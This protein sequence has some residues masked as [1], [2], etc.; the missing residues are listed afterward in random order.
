MPWKET[1]PMKERMR[2]VVTHEADLYAMKEQCERFGISRKTGYKWLERFE[3]EGPDGLEDRSRRPHRSPNQTAENIQALL[4][5][6]RLKHPRWGPEKLLDVVS[7]RHPELEL[8]A[9]STV[10]AILK[11]EGLVKGRRR[12]R[13]HKHPGKPM[14]SVTTPNQLWTADFK[15]EFKTLDG[16]WCYPLTVAD[17]YSRFVLGID[18]MLSTKAKGARVV[19][20]RLFREYGLPCGIRTDNGTPFVGASAIHGLSV[21]SVWWIKLGIQPER[22]LPGRPDQN[23]RHER[24]HRTMKDETQ[25][26]PAASQPAQQECFDDFRHE[27]NHDR[28][29]Q[30]LGQKRPAEVWKPSSRPYP[31]RIPEAEYPKH[32]QRR[33]VCCNGI[34]QFKN[35]R[36]FLSETMAKE[37]IGLEEIQ[38]GIWSIY[39]YNVLLGRFD[40]RKFEL[41][42]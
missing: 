11:R 9:R 18:G 26:P 24:M 30:A 13:R 2:F 42:T 31:E 14:T 35:R 21:L 40:E 10:A 25:Y 36:L 16:V 1:C 7:R 20:E 6:V 38:D 28:P 33:R 12:R 15:G 34:I 32:F 4:I 5:E 8:P 37:D 3:E 39:F 27:F 41:I 29:H 22:I 19:F 23:G 17:E